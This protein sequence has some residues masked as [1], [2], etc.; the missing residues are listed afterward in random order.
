[1][2][3]FLPLHTN[4]NFKR[5]NLYAKYMQCCSEVI[6][7]ALFRIYF[8]LI[9]NKVVEIVTRGTVGKLHHFVPRSKFHAHTKS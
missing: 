2:A 6:Y 1:M 8:Q 4:I 7:V 3:I 5:I 9:I